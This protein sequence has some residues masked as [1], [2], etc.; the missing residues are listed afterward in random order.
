MPRHERRR[1]AQP[2][3]SLQSPESPRRHRLGRGDLVGLAVVALVALAWLAPALGKGLVLGPFDAVLSATGLGHGLYRSVHNAISTD[4]VRQDSAWLF[5]DATA[6]RHGQFPLWNSLN[7]LGLPEFLNFQSGVLSLPSLVAYLVPLPD[8]FATQVLVKLL[9]AGTG[10]YLLA[11]VL[12]AGPTGATLAGVVGELAGPV[13][14]WAG[15]PQTAVSE[16]TGWVLALT[17]LL[18]RRPTRVRLAG[19][20]IALAFAVYGGFPEVF[21]LLA[22][23]AV[24]VVA[25]HAIRRALSWRSLAALGGAVVAGAALAAP[26]WL[27]G[28]EVLRRGAAWGKLAGTLP[29]YAVPALLSPAYFGLPT[30]SSVQFGPV[31]YYET[32]AFVGPIVL[33]LAGVT[34]VR[35]SWGCPAVGGL[36]LAA[37]LL[38][39]AAYGGTAVADVAHLVPIGRSV[40]LSRGLLVLVTILAALAGL[41]LDEVRERRR[42][43]A[44]L[45]VE[46]VL[47]GSVAGALFVLAAPLLAPASLLHFLDPA[48]RRVEGEGLVVAAAME[49]ALAGW[50][51]WPSLRRRWGAVTSRAT[52]RPTTS[53]GSVPPGP[54][55]AGSRDAPTGPTRAR[56]F[57]GAVLVCIQAVVLVGASA[58]I[59]TWGRRY[60]PASPAISRLVDLVGGARVGLAGSHSP[61]GFQ[62]LGILAEANAP[63]GLHELATYDATTE[64]SFERAWERSAPDPAAAAAAIAATPTQFAP[65]IT[66]V[67]QARLFGTAYLLAGLGA[68][69]ALP[70]GR[71]AAGVSRVAVLGGED[72]YHVAGVRLATLAGAPGATAGARGTTGSAGGG[73]VSPVRF[74]ANNVARFV[75]SVRHATWVDVRVADLPGW[76]AAVG[77][78]PA[79]LGV[80]DGAMLAVHVPAGRHVVRLTYLPNLLVVGLWLAVAG[81]AGLVGLAVSARPR[82]RAAGRS[83]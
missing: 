63:Y 70:G 60:Y 27:P 17:V 10:T 71:L 35:R 21:L 59:N 41:G 64:R 13:A 43:G 31:N 9:L 11:R 80:F 47:T 7:G 82:R 29:P 37:G 23:T 81:V 62:S 49:L 3:E 74:V 83:P 18:L 73:T 75:V 68:W 67:A 36:T 33:V 57:G 46:W 53:D 42:V 51:A 55:V 39:V 12:G 38:A 4:Q 44:S 30:T 6:L 8:A 24:V 2:P 14:A 45:R 5:L 20:A 34:V 26:L 28:L 77:G 69:P 72:L 19:L 76:T 79:V 66:S 25:W 15:W 54:G 22:G 50:L 56:G 40:T 58:S 61:A 78:V 1:P 32:A 65:A 48:K 52:P 16:W